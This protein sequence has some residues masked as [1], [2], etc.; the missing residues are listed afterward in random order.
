MGSVKEGLSFQRQVTLSR[1]KLFT[2]INI[3]LPILLYKPTDKEIEEYGQSVKTQNNVNYS[4]NDFLKTKYD[5]ENKQ[6]VIADLSHM[7]ISSHH[8]DVLLDLTSA[9]F[10]GAYFNKTRFI[11]CDLSN[12]IFADCSLNDVLF[13]YCNLNNAD[14]RGCNLETCQFG[15]EYRDEPLRQI[16][17]V[18]L[19]FSGSELRIF[20]DIKNETAKK[21]EYQRLLDIKRF[22][23]REIS[24]KTS[25]WSKIAFY[26]GFSKED[27]D[28][29]KAMEKMQEME[30]GIFSKENPIHN[31][32]K[33]IFENESCNFYPVYEKARKDIRSITHKKYVRLTREDIEEF[34]ATTDQ[35]TPYSLNDFARIKFIIQQGEGY[36]MPADTYVVAD[37]S[38]KVN[39]FGN[40][41]WNRINLS[42]ISFSG[43]D[44]SYVNFSGTDLSK[45]NFSGSILIGTNLNS[46]KLIES[47]FSSADLSDASLINSE[48]ANAIFEDCNLLRANLNWSRAKNIK[49]INSN[50]SY[51]LFKKADWFK[52]N[53]ENVKFDGTNFERAILN[54]SRILNSNFNNCILNKVFFT[55]GIISNCNLAN[56][57]MNNTNLQNSTWNQVKLSN[58]EITRSNLTGVRF[59]SESEIYNTDF[60]ESILDGF[61]IILCKVNNCNFDKTKIGYGKFS[62]GNFTGST[63]RF[64]Q[65]DCTVMASAILD[66]VDFTGAIIYN[67]G[68]MNA[69]LQNSVFHGAKIKNSD[70]TGA[71]FENANWFNL[72]LVASIMENVNNHR[73]RIND[74]TEFLACVIKNVNGQFYHYDEDDFMNV[75]FIEQQ[76]SKQAK[77]RNILKLR[78][79]GIF[80]FILRLSSEKYNI[81]QQEMLSS[82][83]A[84]KRNRQEYKNKILHIKEAITNHISEPHLKIKNL[85]LS[86]NIT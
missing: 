45:C 72:L 74:C 80:A 78:R 69:N 83:K 41:E 25:F 59:S 36:E 70:L 82:L 42:G 1:E 62:N 21:N 61:R 6:T 4:I 65:I 33:Y 10:R 7:D 56:N 5:P 55:E 58:I 48:L 43:K 63:F 85:I 67:T 8:Q 51:C 20:A 15:S 46:C 29:K 77:I 18:K 27:C 81:S 38:S 12:A 28:Y 50:L 86:H 79:Y 34:V 39:K 84:R 66:G 2:G 31:S 14:L 49:V 75:M 32:I 52:A 13:K 60:S 9:N 26:F 53:F 64:A 73:A 19:S 23:L 37:L 11:S 71:N 47:V 57:L 16:K 30:A 54:K 35:P 68:L 76:K 40:N 24:E 17:G 22:E 3:E 44:L